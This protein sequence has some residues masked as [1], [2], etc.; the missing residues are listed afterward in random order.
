[1]ASQAEEFDL[2]AREVFAPIYPVIAKQ[3]LEQTGIE[4]GICVD[5]GCG[6]GY[7]GLSLARASA[8]KVFLMDNDIEMLTI[9]KRNIQEQNLDQQVHILTGDVHSIPLETGSIQLAVSRGSL[10]FWD[11]PAQA[12][13]E[14]FRVL[15]PGG[16]AVIGGGFG[17]AELK[18]QIDR[19]MT[20]RDP[21]WPEKTRQR[22]G[23]NA[24]EKYRQLLLQAE[25]HNF[26]IKQGEA[27]MWITFKGNAE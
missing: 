6:G 4:R 1:M 11:D 17:N 5:I 24:P 16:C 12:F 9:A 23:T 13:R 8:L 20:A 27:G 18:K 7:L 3:I 22:I 26:D 14:I 2:I 19:K 15:A 10:F 21:Q 25:I